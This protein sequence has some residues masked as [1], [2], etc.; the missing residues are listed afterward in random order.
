LEFEKDDETNFHIDFIT[1]A[2]NLRATNYKIPLTN[3]FKTKGIAGKIMPALVTTTSLV[4]GLACIELIKVLS[5]ADK[6]EQ[7]TDSC[8]N[9]GISFF[10]FTEPKPCKK[11]KIGSYEFSQWSN[12]TF[13]NVRL[14][15]IINSVMAKVKDVEIGTIYAGDYVVYDSTDDDID[16]KKLLNTTIGSL[17]LEKLSKKSPNIKEVPDMFKLDIFMNTEDMSDPISCVINC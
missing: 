16:T 8:I 11:V 17:Y 4:S 2:S 10:S 9:L 1:S 12:L 7:Y 3:K 15:E 13:P 6:I 14:Q 5:G